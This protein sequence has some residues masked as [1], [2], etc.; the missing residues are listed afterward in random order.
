[1]DRT[2]EDWKA[3]ID[4][5]ITGLSKSDS[6]DLP[7]LSVDV[8]TLPSYIDHTLLSLDATTEQIDTLCNEAKEY[9][10]KVSVHLTNYY[11]V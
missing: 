8:N 1:M 6:T 9:N 5:V 3:I 11:T 2:N 7:V 4:S 10:F